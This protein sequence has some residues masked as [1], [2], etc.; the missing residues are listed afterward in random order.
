[1]KMWTRTEVLITARTY[2]TP[3]TK[4]IEVSCTGGI[5]RDGR[6][7]R[8]YPV[9][10]RFLDE[11]KRFHKYQWIEASAAKSSDSRPE[12]F[13]LDP[14][15]IHILTEPL[16]TAA[17]WKARKDIIAP[18][19]SPSLCWLQAERDKHQSPTLGFFKPKEIRR[20]L[21]E[22]DEPWTAAELAKL[23]R[24]PLFGIA[25]KEELEQIPYKFKYQFAC[26]D[27]TCKGHTVSCVDWEMGQSYRSWSRK[28][29]DWEAAFRKKY[30][31]EMIDKL[32]THFFVGTVRSHP[33][34]WIIIGLFYPPK[35]PQ[36]TKQ[37]PLF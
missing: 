8:L 36:G 1:M 35:E 4:G 30:E 16:T 20:L 3:A 14:D 9:P 7:I 32:D 33:G 11:D 18:L 13:H 10:Y 5:T 37:I 2:P 31:T 6:W 28:Y 19:A 17:Y 22:P 15:S 27:P 26:D 25:P 29:A 21:L 34:A 12:S 24:N 23:R